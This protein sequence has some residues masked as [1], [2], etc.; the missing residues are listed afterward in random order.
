[1]KVFVIGGK[2]KS[3]KNTLANFL[4]EELKVKG[5]N[6]CIMHITEP[7][8]LYAEKYFDWNGKE[9]TKPREFLQ[10]VGIEIIKEKLGKKDFLINRCF[11]DIEILS[12]FFDTFIICDAR[13]VDEF[14]AFKSKYNDSITIKIERDNLVNNLSEEEKNHI[15]EI[16]IDNYNDFDYIIKNTSLD[17]LELEAKKIVDKSLDEII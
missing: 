5:Y 12:E 9:E 17:K 4:K 11:E 2:A 7:L 8:Y 1:M 3:G 15:T 16:E 13:L 10:K 14:M 6:P